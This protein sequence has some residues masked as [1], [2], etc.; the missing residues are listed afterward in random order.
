M[1]TETLFKKGTMVNVSPDANFSSI[2]EAR[3]FKSAGFIGRVMHNF[4]EGDPFVHVEV[5]DACGHRRDPDAYDLL[6]TRYLTPVATAAAQTAPVSTDA[7]KARAY[8]A[9]TT[10][11]NMLLELAPNDP[12]RMS[13][14]LNSSGAHE[15]MGRYDMANRIRAAL[16]HAQRVADEPSHSDDPEVETRRFETVEV[17]GE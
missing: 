9:L 5:I 12:P 17:N 11:L 2:D 6:L 15:D 3:T 4:Y 7:A 8:D 10:Q 16:T 1:K 14:Y 13:K